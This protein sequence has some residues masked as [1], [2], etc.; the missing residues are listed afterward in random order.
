MFFEAH[1]FLLWGRHNSHGVHH[2]FRI[3][4]LAHVQIL[5]RS[6]HVIA[7]THERSIIF[8]LGIG[9][10]EGTP[11]IVANNCSHDFVELGHDC[12][13]IPTGLKEGRFA[14]EAKHDPPEIAMQAQICLGRT[15][16]IGASYASLNCLHLRFRDWRQ[17][18]FVAFNFEY[19]ST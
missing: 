19:R 11:A 1:L 6:V 7:Q 13:N 16:C 4:Q 18:V 5:V 8:N 3:F 17:I 10:E 9:E 12:S 14:D 15:G 2:I